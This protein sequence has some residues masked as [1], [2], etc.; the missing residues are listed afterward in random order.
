MLYEVI[1]SLYCLHL[2]RQALQG[3][4]VRLSYPELGRA[5]AVEDPSLPGGFSY[6]VNARQLTA[7]IDELLQAGLLQ[8]VGPPQSEHYHQA[9]VRLPLLHTAPTSPLPKPAFAMEVTWRPDEQF[10]YNFV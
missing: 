6:Q 2:R 8:L 4:P 1:T 9:E 3:G 7:L 10:S 5:L